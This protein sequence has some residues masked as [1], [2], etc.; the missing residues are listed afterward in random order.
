MILAHI[1]H[2]NNKSST[3]RQKLERKKNENFVRLSKILF[4]RKTKI[5]Q[6][7]IRA[8]MKGTSG[9]DKTLKIA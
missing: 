5:R 6:G 3:K 7:E 8:E 9:L 2:L 4:S 1:N